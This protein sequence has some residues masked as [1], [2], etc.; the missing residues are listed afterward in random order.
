MSIYKED[1]EA[2]MKAIQLKPHYAEAHHILGFV[3]LNVGNKK[4]AIKQ[5][6]ILKGLDKDLANELLA[7]IDILAPAK[8]LDPKKKPLGSNPYLP[9]F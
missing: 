6:E 3:Y 4:A 7:Y 9:D 2:L 1:T 8:R 5:Q